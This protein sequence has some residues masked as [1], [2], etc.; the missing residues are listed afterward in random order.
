MAIFLVD[1]ENVNAPG[2]QGI[3]QLIQEDEVLL[4]YTEK[5]A[6]LPIALHKKI[7]ASKAKTDYFE[8]GS[9]AKNSL[10]FQLASYL[11][12]LVAK[13]PKGEYYIVS[14]D[15][16]FRAVKEFWLKRDIKVDLAMN[17]LKHSTAIIETK[18]KE[19]IPQ[20]ADD[21]P[22]VRELME[23]YKTKQGLNNALIKE[24]GSEKTGILYKAIKP[25]LADKKGR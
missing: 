17:L 21:I 10:D 8:V 13:E 20:Y 22:L 7:N 14:K 4:F 19:L 25:L 3:D 11:G 2:L 18:L 1:Y 24:Y 12:Y 23:R 6:T 15:T 5:A 9:G 16:G